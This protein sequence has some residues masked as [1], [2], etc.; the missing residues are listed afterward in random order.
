MKNT[1]LDGITIN[2]SKEKSLELF[3]TALCNGLSYM[4][5]YGLEIVY[6]E[7]QYKHSR[8]YFKE[9]NK[10]QACCY[11]DVLVQMLKDGNSIGILDNE[12]QSYSKT[13]NLQNVYDRVQKTP[14]SHLFDAIEENGDAITADVI[15]QT[16]FFEDVV[17]G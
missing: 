7:N 11:E 4:Y 17:F 9:Q 12:Y 16:V 10:Q 2:L 15:L 8:D 13:I 1:K 14:I 6:D 3:H 5:G